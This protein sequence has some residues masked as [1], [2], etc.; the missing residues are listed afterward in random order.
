MRAVSTLET[1]SLLLR[2]YAHMYRRFRATPL[3]F[4]ERRAGFYASYWEDAARQL[5]ACVNRLGD[6]YLEVARN[7]SSARVKDNCVDLDTYFSRGLADD[8]VFVT[9]LVGELGFFAPRFREYTLRS[10]S[11][12]V[13]FLEEVGAPC[14]VKPRVGSG[15]CGITT[16]VNT[17]RR[18]I[19]ASL[20]PS[21]SLTLPALMIE[22]Q[23]AGDSYRLLYLDGSL[24]H[25]VKRGRC[26]VIGDGLST[27]RE[28]VVRENESRLTDSRLQSLS[29]L[30]IDLEMKYTLTDQGKTLRTIPDRGERVVVKNVCNQNC[31]RDQEEVTAYVHGDYD[32][33]A[34]AVGT[35]LGAHLIGIDVMSEE[36]SASPSQS[37]SAITEINIPP[38]LHYHELVEHQH[39][40]SGVG[41]AVLEYLL[42]KA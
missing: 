18:L 13:G 29:P 7:G 31:R 8:K 9:G 35:R 25:A 42:R 16:A 41:A 1:R 38:G 2:R 32:Q 6:D 14:V 10:L 17:R 20:A 15:G 28:L 33:L 22:Q 37:G 27:I 30:T 11:S 24:L 34:S 5:G 21:N 23:I 36:I 19:E 39:N 40:Y 12:A 26:T 4:N 3:N